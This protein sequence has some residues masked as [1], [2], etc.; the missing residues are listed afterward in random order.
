EF[1]DSAHVT[2]AEF[3]KAVQTRHAL[4]IRFDMPVL[5]TM[6]GGGAL[7]SGSPTYAPAGLPVKS[8]RGTRS[9]LVLVGQESSP[10]VGTVAPAPN[11][12]GSPPAAAGP[13]APAT[14]APAPAAAAPA[15][16]PA[17]AAVPAPPDSSPP[18]AAT[19]A[20]D[21]SAT[22]AEAAPA[23]SKSGAKGEHSVEGLLE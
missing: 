11:R 6:F 5:A 3:L 8:A 18:A 9:S 15:A 4:S 19:P 20:P 2:L 21:A 14:A 22:P 23:E 13:P 16:A 1:A 10:V 17:P 12:V 7:G